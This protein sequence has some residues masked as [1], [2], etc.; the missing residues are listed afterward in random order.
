MA[1]YLTM[2]ERI[3]DEMKRPDLDSQVRRAIQDAIVHYQDEVFYVAEVTGTVTLT[4]GQEFHTLPSDFSQAIKW[5][6]L[7]NGTRQILQQKTIGALKAWDT[8]T[9]TATEGIPRWVALLGDT[10]TVYP[11]SEDSAYQAEIIYNSN[12]AAPVTDADQGFWMMNGER[13]IRTTAKSYVYSDT[14]KNYDFSRAEE[15]LARTEYSRL[16]S[17][18]EARAYDGVVQAW[19]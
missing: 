12:I 7:Y 16:V 4:K 13:L 17:K 14:L 10:F 18:T 3:K 5:F 19:L 9:T 8:N 1:D 15:E 11:R 6:I 2:V